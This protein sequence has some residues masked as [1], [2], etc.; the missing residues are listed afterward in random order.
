MSRMYDELAPWWP[1]MS[2][3]ADY[4]EE[5]AFYGALLAGGARAPAAHAARARQRRRQQR[6]ALKA[7]F[8]MT[9]VEPARRACCEV[10]RALNPECEHVAGRHAHGAARS[11]SSMRSSCTTPSC[12][13]TTEADLR[14][15]DRDR[16]RP[17]PARRRRAVR[18]RPPARELPSRPPIT[19]ATTATTARPALPGVDAG[20]P[21]RPT[22]RIPWTTP[23]CFASADGIRARRPRPPRRGPVLAR[24]LAAAARARPASSRASCRSSTRSS[25][26]ARM[27]CSS[28][29]AEGL[30]GS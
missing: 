15:G 20:T 9:L 18:P 8:A 19:A 11:R 30:G 6:V 29:R 3:P 25:S 28:R 22:P 4:E 23:T 5:A 16:L 1:L 24:R 7:R 27:R 17:L 21:T 2:A 10:S 13:M 12:Y 14:R 26:P